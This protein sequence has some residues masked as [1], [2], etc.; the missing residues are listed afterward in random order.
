[1]I[2]P[3]ALG[4]A[5]EDP[6]VQEFVGAFSGGYPRDPLGY[7]QFF[8][9]LVGAD[10]RLPDP[11][12]PRL[13]LGAR[14]ALAERFPTEAEV[15]LDALRAAAFPKLVVSGGHHEALDAVCDVLERKLGAERAVI[16]GAGHSVAR[17][18]KPFNDVLVDFVERAGVGD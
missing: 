17:T 10:T 16:P 12:P 15:P 11:L 6:A 1:M 3:P 5:P 13:E 18:G 4:L 8:L 9:S 2:E 7:L 14:A